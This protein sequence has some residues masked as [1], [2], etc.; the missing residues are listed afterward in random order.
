MKTHGWKISEEAAYLLG[1]IC[2]A[3]G[4]TLQVK[5][6]LGLSMVAAPAYLLSVKIDG[7]SM[8]MAEWL[9][10]G[11]LYLVCCIW[12]GQFL[13]K[14]LWSFAAA[15][16]YGWLLDLVMYLCRGIMPGGL[17]SRFVFFFAGCASLSAGIALMIRSYL[18][19]QAYEMFVQVAAELTGR[20]FNRIKLI[21]DWCSLLTALIMSW[22]FFGR[23]TGIG[24]GTLLCTVINAP[25]IM[26]WGRMYERLFD[27]HP[28]WP[29]VK[30]A[31]T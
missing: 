8:G 30:R 17:L 18:P 15:I 12:A 24:I 13:K 10:Q 1:N 14:R 31:L 9:I 20:P 25:L 22:A 16:P 7:L 5:A 11:L 27:M 3:L 23:L 28:L 26:F 2:C 19:C 21:Y 29:G 6:N 4:I